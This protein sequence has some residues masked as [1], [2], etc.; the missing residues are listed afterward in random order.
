MKIQKISFENMSALDFLNDIG[1]NGTYKSFKSLSHGEYIIRKFSEVESP[2]GI[3]IRIDFD[4]G[5]SYLPERYNQLSEEQI[6]EL[7]STSKMLIYSGKD[8]DNGER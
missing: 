8:R 3:R 5:Y 6:K 2:W 1:G 7:N 4:N